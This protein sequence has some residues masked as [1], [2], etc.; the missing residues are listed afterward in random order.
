MI[1]AFSKSLLGAGR[2]VPDDVINIGNRFDVYRNNYL[3]GLAGALSDVFPVLTQLVGQEYFDSVAHMFALEQPP[4]SPVLAFY[5]SGF[6]D[7]LDAFEPLKELP[8]LPGVA[9][10]EWA[11]QVAATVDLAPTYLI[12][13]ASD[14]EHALGL[15]VRFV[16]GT[17][18]IR[19]SYPVA[20]IWKHHQSNPVEPVPEWLPEHVA[21]WP[22]QG[23]VRL[24]IISQ[25]QMSALSDFV[26]A[27]NALEVLEAATDEGRAT[28]LM[29][30]FATFINNGL[31]VP[32]A[33][34]F[35]VN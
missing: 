1:S 14:L 33:P 22:V 31:L 16:P 26:N 25:D 7:F 3:V 34:D 18:L 28:H 2:N 11:R 19:S 35:G 24:E 20:T 23:P 6:P 30:T 10:V 8:Y 12:E 4:V 29:S 5:G 17:T 27:R 32:S 21:V 15:R 9:R 13:N